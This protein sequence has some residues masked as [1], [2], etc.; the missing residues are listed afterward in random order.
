[1]TEKQ[2]ADV[3]GRYGP[4]RMCEILL[5]MENWKP[6]LSKNRSVHLTFLNWMRREDAEKERRNGKKYEKPESGGRPLPD[7]N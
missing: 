6:L 5:A 4:E 7:L 3:Y 2:F 1:M